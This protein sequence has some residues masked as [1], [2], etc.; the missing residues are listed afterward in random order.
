MLDGVHRRGEVYLRWLQRFSALAFGT[1][2]GA[3]LTR[4]LALPFGGSFV[5]LKGLEEID[6]LTIAR[7][8]GPSSSPGQPRE[9]VCCWARSRWG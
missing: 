8:T 2:V 1:P 5:L 4:Y 9:H 7:L 3:F 6:E